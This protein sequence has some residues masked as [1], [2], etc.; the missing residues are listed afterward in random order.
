MP[1]ALIVKIALAVGYPV[2]EYLIGK[3]T[4]IQG[5][6]LIEVVLNKIKSIRK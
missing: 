3:S 2:L 6:S 4:N 5:N 1:A